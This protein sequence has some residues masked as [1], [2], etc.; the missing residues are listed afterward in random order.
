MSSTARRDF[1]DRMRA[2]EGDDTN[3]VV[4]I[5]PRDDRRLPEP[6]RK[7]S[8]QDAAIVRGHA[9]AAALK[10]A[11]HDPAV[12]RRL[13]P[14]GQHDVGTGCRHRCGGGRPDPAAGPGDYGQPPRQ[15]AGW[16]DI[17]APH[18][19]THQPVA[20]RGARARPGSA[21]GRAGSQRA[22]GRRAAYST[23]L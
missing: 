5:R 17:G 14:G 1:W 10:L 12:H 8:K 13:I 6:P 16:G 2:G 18:H 23:T 21:P 20:G 15:P 22:D 3:P 19:L 7:M 9:D 4:T 11:C